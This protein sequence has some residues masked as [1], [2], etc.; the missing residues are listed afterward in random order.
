MVKVG[1]L[2]RSRDAAGVQNVLAPTPT[3]FTTDIGLTAVDTRRSPGAV[4]AETGHS[5]SLKAHTY[6]APGEFI[7]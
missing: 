1:L 5:W 7:T 6:S 4:D 2:R 3:L